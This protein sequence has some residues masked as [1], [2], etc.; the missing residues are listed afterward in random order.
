MSVG[1]GNARPSLAPE[2]D[3]KS[4]PIVRGIARMSKALPVRKVEPTNRDPPDS[5]HDFGDRHAQLW[6]LGIV[7]LLPTD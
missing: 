7:L 4:V 3:G 6:Y 5:R 1:L 2:R